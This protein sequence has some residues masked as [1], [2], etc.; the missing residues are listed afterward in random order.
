M[1]VLS[2]RPTETVSGLGAGLAIYGFCTQVGL[3][4][5]AAAIL[6]VI[7]VVVPFLV[8]EIVDIVRPHRASSSD[9]RLSPSVK[10]RIT[11]GK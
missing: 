8:S 1:S 4:Q 10:G 5:L 6:A 3:P 11:K 9:E 2:K 7:V